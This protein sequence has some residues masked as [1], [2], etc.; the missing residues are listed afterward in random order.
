MREILIILILLIS[1]PS[2]ACVELDEQSHYED[3]QYS[4]L[5]DVGEPIT[6]NLDNDLPSFNVTGE[7]TQP[8]DYQNLTAYVDYIPDKVTSLTPDNYIKHAAYLPFEV[9]RQSSLTV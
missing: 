1:F 9:G 4:Q 5:L 7:N 3:H 2:F 8:I 6:I